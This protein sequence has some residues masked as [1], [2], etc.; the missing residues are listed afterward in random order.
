MDVTAT[1][2]RAER[3]APFREVDPETDPIIGP[4]R[5]AL[6]IED[7]GNCFRL[8]ERDLSVSTDPV[9][10]VVVPKKERN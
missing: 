10:V 6:E 8:I 5:L 7:S 3:E 9:E 1:L 4:T 2:T